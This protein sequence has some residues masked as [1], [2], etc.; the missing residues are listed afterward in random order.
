MSIPI[1][2]SYCEVKKHYLKSLFP[3]AKIRL[4]YPNCTNSKETNM[5]DQP[6]NASSATADDA[7]AMESREWMDALSAVIANEGPER[8]R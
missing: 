5:S 2:I 4:Q 1:N 6:R 3:C 7:N 8:A